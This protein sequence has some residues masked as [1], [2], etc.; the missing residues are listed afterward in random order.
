MRTPRAVAAFGAA[1]AVTAVAVA[2]VTVSSTSPAA[3]AGIATSPASCPSSLMPSAKRT[4][5]RQDYLVLS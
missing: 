3:S 5:P 1:T 4:G 2:A